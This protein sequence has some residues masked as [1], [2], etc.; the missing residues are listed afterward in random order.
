METPHCLPNGHHDRLPLYDAVTQKDASRIAQYF[1]HKRISSAGIDVPLYVSSDVADEFGMTHF[2]K[3]N[4]NNK[5][6]VP[7]PVST[8]VT[9][10]RN[11]QVVLMSPTSYELP[12]KSIYQV[13]CYFRHGIRPSSRR[14]GR[15]NID[16]SSDNNNS[17][18]DSQRKDTV[19]ELIISVQTFL[20]QVAVS[21]WKTTTTPRSASRR[22]S[23]EKGEVHET[24]ETPRVWLDRTVK[25]IVSS[26]HVHL[27]GIL[28]TV[29]SLGQVRGNG[30]LFARWIDQVLHAVPRCYDND[31]GDGNNPQ[32]GELTRLLAWLQLLQPH[33]RDLNVRQWVALIRNINKVL[34]SSIEGVVKATDALVLMRRILCIYRVACGETS[35]L[36]L[37]MREDRIWHGLVFRLYHRACT[38]ETSCDLFINLHRG[39]ESLLVTVP[40]NLLI[41]WLRWTLQ[42]KVDYRSIPITMSVVIYK[43]WCSKRFD[44]SSSQGTNMGPILW[45]ELSTFLFSASTE[46]DSGH[47]GGSDAIEFV[48]KTF[49]HCCYKGKGLIS[50]PPNNNAA[51]L[52]DAAAL[53]WESFR[54][55]GLDASSQK[56]LFDLC[57]EMMGTY[58]EATSGFDMILFVLLLP[59]LYEHSP[60][61]QRLILAKMRHCFSRQDEQEGM[62]RILCVS[63][64][65]MTQM[66]PNDDDIWRCLIP[67]LRQDIPSEVCSGIVL[68]LVGNGK[69]EHEISCLCQEW[70]TCPLPS[71]VRRDRGSEITIGSFERGL[72]IFGI[73]L[74]RGSVQARMKS[75]FLVGSVLDGSK[76]IPLVFREQLYKCVTG[77]LRESTIDT[78]ALETIFRHASRGLFRVWW[79]YKEEVSVSD[80]TGQSTAYLQEAVSVAR[81][82]TRVLSAA[83]KHSGSDILVESMW[84]YEM[85]TDALFAVLLEWHCLR[86]D[87]SLNI[88]PNPRSLDVSNNDPYVAS[89]VLSLSSVFQVIIDA[90]CDIEVLEVKGISTVE[91]MKEMRSKEFGSTGKSTLPQSSTSKDSIFRIAWLDLVELSLSEGFWRDKPSDQYKPYVLALSSLISSS[92][93]RTGIQSPEIEL[94]VAL[95]LLDRPLLS[96]VFNDFSSQKMTAEQVDSILALVLFICKQ[97]GSMDVARTMNDITFQKIILL[98]DLFCSEE[99][100]A[101]M[102]NHLEFVLGKLGDDICVGQVLDLT[103][104]EH[105][106][107]SVRKFRSKV[108]KSIS[109]FFEVLAT[110]PTF[111]PSSPRRENVRA[112]LLSL[113]R[114]F[115]MGLRCGSG[116]IDTDLCVSFIDCIEMVHNN[117]GTKDP[118]WISKLCHETL[119]RIEGILQAINLN[120][121]DIVDSLLSLSTNSLPAIVNNAF[122]ESCIKT[123]SHIQGMPTDIGSICDDLF[124]MCFEYNMKRLNPLEELYSQGS[125]RS[126]LVS[127]PVDFAISENSR[128]SNLPE[129]LQI[130]SGNNSGAAGFL[131]SLTVLFESDKTWSWVFKAVLESYRDLLY[132]AAKD[133]RIF[134][135]ATENRLVFAKSYF[136]EMKNIGCNILGLFESSQGQK[137]RNQTPTFVATTLPSNVKDCLCELLQQFCETLLESL[138]LFTEVLKSENTFSVGCTEALCILTAWLFLEEDICLRLRMWYKWEERTASRA[139]AKQSVVVTETS[140]IK[141][142]TKVVEQVDEIVEQLASVYEM[143]RTATETSVFNDQRTLWGETKDFVDDVCGES[144]DF[145]ERL[146]RRVKA[147]RGK[148]TTTAKVHKVVPDKATVPVKR[149]KRKSPSEPSTCHRNQLVEDWLRRDKET[150]DGKV[151]DDTFADLED[152]LVED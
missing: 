41:K 18:E 106:D 6:T 151:G 146:E 50:C 152:F 116:G 53:L 10:T 54:V 70:I 17:N 86:N 128:F 148:A 111:P 37:A 115:K 64:R 121:A 66:E 12:W 90:E 4:S 74:V 124:G 27:F 59:I 141:D 102:L 84:P 71:C 95:M 40:N 92:K 103:D 87:S 47:Q 14:S 26:G 81:L 5:S 85:F 122:K 75:L 72:N 43:A 101:D 15:C 118:W 142:L 114:D 55:I 3:N 65:L 107:G 33:T 1:Q 96:E 39:L 32:E 147:L 44:Q 49:D 67:I 113:L 76:T 36:T 132:Y 83:K 143:L 94:D 57:F 61:T 13:C 120:N 100:V 80:A 9:M 42:T 31:T 119:E 82:L 28:S 68:A 110:G 29:L 144:F 48:F 11:L 149:K 2:T 130:K 125:N 105:L 24:S 99:S 7:D 136:G 98:Y 8:L 93:S 51:W 112:F 20:Q 22:T 88:V 134:F 46:N 45:E 58:F 69:A 123:T 129:T 60:I 97:I 34:Q 38:T 62:L 63:L 133:S 127:A 30:E 104:R 79:R 145:L 25:E 150:G 35:T 78:F 16:D 56:L 89:A 91:M 139:G 109:T 21:E 117:L 135:N 77:I 140:F 131:P 23:L 52:I 19:M 138:C 126:T 108:L 137:S 73:L